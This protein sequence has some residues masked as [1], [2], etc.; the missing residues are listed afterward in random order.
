MI[1][2]LSKLIR[3]LQRVPV[4][5]AYHMLGGAIIGSVLLTVL[6]MITYTSLDMLLGISAYVILVT[7]IAWGIEI[8]QLYSKT[9]QYDNYDAIAVLLGSTIVLMPFIVLIYKGI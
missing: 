8:F 7:C 1:D 5:K 4:D 3:L 2:K 9:G 6:A